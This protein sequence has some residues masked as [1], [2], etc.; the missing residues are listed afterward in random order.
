MASMYR[1]KHTC[2]F[3]PSDGRIVPLAPPSGMSLFLSAWVD[4]RP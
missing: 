4:A 1:S 2:G 3:A